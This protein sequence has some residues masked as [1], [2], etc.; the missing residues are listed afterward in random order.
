MSPLLACR[1]CLGSL[2]PLLLTSQ[3]D[4]TRGPERAMIFSS[5]M[6]TS[7]SI[8][9]AVPLFGAKP[10]SYGEGA[11]ER[12]KYQMIE[13]GKGG[14]DKGCPDC[15]SDPPQPVWK[16]NDPTWDFSIDEPHRRSAE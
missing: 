13:F 4:N 1:G 11:V 15:V 8:D 12:P 7:L 10:Y 9:P 5:L 16:Y 3:Q 6:M 14:Q 2:E